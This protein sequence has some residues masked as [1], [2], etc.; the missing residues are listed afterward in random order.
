MPPD[1]IAHLLHH[2]EH[3][4]QRMALRE[5]NRELNYAELAYRVL[6]MAAA[7]RQMGIKPQARLIVWA[8]K[9][10]E[11]VVALLAAL[12]A[13]IVFV[14]LHPALRAPQV[15]D[16]FNRAQAHGLLVDAPHAAA[17]G[18][19]DPF[20]GELRFSLHP[21][22]IPQ[23]LPEAEASTH[24]PALSNGDPHRLAALLYTSG[25]TGLPKG[26][27][28]TR[29]N[30]N[31]GAN[32]VSRYL[33]LNAHDE[34]LAILPLSFDYGLSQITTALTVGA[35]ITLQDYLLPN[36]LKK[37]L[38]DGGITVMAGTPGLLI[39]LARQAWLS[40]AP[41][42]RLITNSGGKLPV[43]S[44][45]A[46]RSARPQTKIFLMYGLTEAF[47]ASFLPPQ[48]VDDHPDSIG[49][50]FEGSHLEL[51]D[52]TG[53]LLP[54]QAAG[55]GELLQ[56]GPL[57][58]AGYFNDPEAT[59]QR[60]RAPPA[61]WPHP[62][63]D[64]VVYS[65]DRMRRDAQGRLYFLGRMD[66]Q[67]KSQGMRVSPEEIEGVAL[68]FDGV[69][70]ALAFGYQTDGEETRIGLV[71]AP[72]TIA[73]NALQTWLQARLAPF[74]M[75]AATVAVDALPRSNNGKLD[76]QASRALFLDRRAASS[77]KRASSP[78]SGTLAP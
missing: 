12:A 2:A 54:A 11:T 49:R 39:P 8:N 44:V 45:H 71:V 26:V 46:L 40:E 77:T 10:L 16:I 43:A 35:G 13:D 34:L 53:R 3:R 24:P 68:Q 41:N 20:T 29:A 42:L 62:E 15:R 55:E 22:Q 58:T 65:G 60:F 70:E 7:L 5:G 38:L 9:R 37:P 51:V 75:P 69:T 32:A 61:G 47:R 27:M 18:F 48:E 74:Q 57:V 59:A 56:G 63:D 76:R 14:P 31:G 28:V 30:L 19:S 25:S 33:D 36:D 50:A 23:E 78:N 21:D 6:A 52:A 72:E 4:P 67:I 64:R 1:L 66:E 73:T 17:L